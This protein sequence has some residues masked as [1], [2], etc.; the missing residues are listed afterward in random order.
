MAPGSDVPGRRDAGWPPLAD[1]RCNEARTADGGEACR[2]PRTP[3][4]DPGLALVGNAWL[5]PAVLVETSRALRGRRPSSA[6]MPGRTCRA[7]R[8]HPEDDR[9]RGL[10]RCSARSVGQGRLDVADNRRDG[11][12]PSHISHRTRPGRGVE[13]SECLSPGASRRTSCPRDG[14]ETR[15]RSF[16]G[17]KF[18]SCSIV[19]CRDPPFLDLE[20]VVKSPS[21]PVPILR[22]HEPSASPPVQPPTSARG[23]NSAPACE[24]GARPSV[25]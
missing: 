21:V 18:E 6:Q 1:R 7:N 3:G 20:G 15:L 13:P 25:W 19:V 16:E 2:G 9:S 14:Q 10:A 24:A 12:E 23:R 22:R 11:Q 5:A 17:Q 4:A 8:A